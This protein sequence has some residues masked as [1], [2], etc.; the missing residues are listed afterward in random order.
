MLQH[1]VQ[2]ERQVHVGVVQYAWESMSIP[3]WS[4]NNIRVIEFASDL[5]TCAM[6]LAC[7]WRALQPRQL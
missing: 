4:H 7:H 5:V 2:C 6:F 1:Y 3:M